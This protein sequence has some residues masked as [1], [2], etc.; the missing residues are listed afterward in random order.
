MKHI[1]GY[2]FSALLIA[3][4][5][6]SQAQETPKDSVTKPAKRERYGLRVG[7]DLFKL[8]RSVYDDNYKGIEFTG[9]YRF[10]RKYWLAAE[11]GNEQKTTEDDRLNFATKGSY[12]RV[13]F[14]YNMHENWL[15][16]ENMIYV[17]LRY[18]FS[19]FSQELNSYRAYNPNPYFNESPQVQVGQEFSGLSAHWGEVVVGLKTQVVNNLFVG[20]SFRM[21]M[22]FADT[23]PQG[24]ENLY[25]PGFN[26]TYGGSFGVGFNYSVSYFIPLYKKQIPQLQ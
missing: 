17:G 19:T 18:G 22:L 1:S 20:F 12:A 13:G 6:L 16:L 3:C 4:T 7:V 9:D 24:F 25:I 10:N 11:L 2:F 21:N 15:N 8:S 5:A 23:R 26:R 14:D